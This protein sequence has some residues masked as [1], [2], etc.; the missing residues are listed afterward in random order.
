ML[1]SIYSPYSYVTTKRKRPA[2]TSINVAIA[3]APFGDDVEKEQP[4]STAIDDY[5]HYMGDV[6]IAN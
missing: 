3:R 4:I 6:D 1:S 2:T 5:N